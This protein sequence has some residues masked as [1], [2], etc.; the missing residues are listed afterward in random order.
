MDF[1]LFRAKCFLVDLCVRFE[2]VLESAKGQLLKG[3]ANPGDAS[4][5]GP[6]SQSFLSFI[7]LPT[8]FIF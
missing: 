2:E 7:L 8:D 3:Y 4:C 6:E 5:R 1:V